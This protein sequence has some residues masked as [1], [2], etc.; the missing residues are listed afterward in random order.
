M[1]RS[2]NIRE[3]AINMWVINRKRPHMSLDMCLDIIKVTRS[4]KDS[5]DHLD[6]TDNYEVALHVLN[7]LMAEYYSLVEMNF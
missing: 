2:K 3:M 4:L 5:C 1:E 6:A 7:M